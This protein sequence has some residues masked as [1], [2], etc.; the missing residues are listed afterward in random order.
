MQQIKKTMKRESQSRFDKLDNDNNLTYIS[1]LV[2]NSNPY[3]H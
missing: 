1:Q 2:L 3:E